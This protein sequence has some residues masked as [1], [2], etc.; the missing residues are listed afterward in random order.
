ME[1]G[2]RVGDKMGHRKWPHSW[3]HCFPGPQES[4]LGSSP[5]VAACSFSSDLAFND[6]IIDASLWVE[7]QMLLSFLFSFKVQAANAAKAYSL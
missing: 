7:S 4:H 3:V 6:L 5:A 2:R 1:E